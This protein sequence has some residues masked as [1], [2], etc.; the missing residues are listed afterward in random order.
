MQFTY[1]DGPITLQ[2]VIEHDE[3][4][5]FDPMSGHYTQPGEPFI[6][7]ITHAGVDITDIVCDD[8]KANIIDEYKKGI[9]H[10]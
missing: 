2:C 5:H 3:T 4:D 8:T 10:V 6:D 9:N 7:Q 1:I